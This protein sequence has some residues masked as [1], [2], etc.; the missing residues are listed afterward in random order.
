MSGPIGIS[1][2]IVPLWFK[3]RIELGDRVRASW[4][5]AARRALARL[6]GPFGIDVLTKGSNPFH[7]NLVKSNPTASAAKPASS[8]SPGGDEG[9]LRRRLAAKEHWKSQPSHRYT[10]EELKRMS[11]AAGVTIQRRKRRVMRI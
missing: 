1:A 9:E 6:A 4:A 7:V 3:S 5:I 2:P 11:E 10:P 8:A